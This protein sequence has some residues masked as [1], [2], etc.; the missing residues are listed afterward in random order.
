MLTGFKFFSI[1]SAGQMNGNSHPV[2]VHGHSFQVLKLGWPNYEQDT[3][4]YSSQANDLNCVLNPN[5]NRVEWTNT[6]W[7]G[8]N[9]PNIVPHSPVLKDT[10]NVPPGGYIV[11]RFKADNPGM[12]KIFIHEF[13]KK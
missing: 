5:C 10:I 9:V 7:Y 6:S 2:H 4:F 12:V 13:S 8:G 1:F 11:V 3:K